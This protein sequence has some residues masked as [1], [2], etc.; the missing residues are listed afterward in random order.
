M[1]EISPPISL[2]AESYQVTR[3]RIHRMRK[4][5]GLQPD[6]FADPDSIFQR[7]L[8]DGVS[9]PMR[10]RL[11]DPSHRAYIKSKLTQP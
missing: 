7:M 1:N 8:T 5:Y 4:F 2:I 11:S 6:D 10:T 9:S 3:Q